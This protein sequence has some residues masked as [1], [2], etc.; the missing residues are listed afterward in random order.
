MFVQRKFMPG[1]LTLGF[2]LAVVS[3]LMVFTWLN[4]EESGG[5]ELTLEYP[6]GAVTANGI[7][8]SL[9]WETLVERSDVIV[10]GTV[11]KQNEYERTDAGLPGMTGILAVYAIEVEEYLKG[12]GPA[13]LELRKTVVQEFA[14]GMLGLE[15]GFVSYVDDPHPL[16]ENARYIFALRRHEGRFAGTAEPFRFRLEDGLAVAESTMVGLTDSHFARGFPARSEDAVVA[17]VRALVTDGKP[18]AGVAP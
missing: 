11:G 13:T 1:A 4:A 7:V 5:P 14:A 17:D 3:A 15:E 2:V 16:T 10:I 6:V 12:S 8:F 9:P 18:S